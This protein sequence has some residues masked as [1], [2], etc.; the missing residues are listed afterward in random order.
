MLSAAIVLGMGTIGEMDDRAL[1]VMTFN[2]RYGT[3]PDGEN[4]WENRREGVIGLIK[5]NDPDVLG[6][7][8]ALAEQVD[9]ISAALPDYGVIGVGRDDGVRKGEFSAL[10]YRRS[11]LK[12]VRSA[13]RWISDEPMKVGSIG[14]GANLPRIFCWGEFERKG[15]GRILVVNT[16]WDH[17]SAPA[18]MLGATQIGEFLGQEKGLPA[19][20]MGDFNCL[21][22][23]EPVK[24]LVS[25]GLSAARPKDGPFVS[26]Q[27]F[28][29]KVMDGDMI[30]HILVSKQWDL[31]SVKIDRTLLP[32]GRTPS[33]HYPVVARM[34][35]KD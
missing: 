35:L 14:P 23:S 19:V 21:P 9:E 28:D 25:L 31:S 13:T 30:D 18:R 1:T 5:T 27:G 17:Q 33:D 8:E 3:A 12:V 11:A 15:M 34:R 24:H 16:H 2:V 26:F 32:T 20:V 4:R 7:Q 29:P 10:L 6:V 22:D